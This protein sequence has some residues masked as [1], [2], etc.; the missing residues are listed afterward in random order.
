MRPYYLWLFTLLA[1]ALAQDYYEVLGVSRSASEKEIKSAYRA[2]SKKFHPDKNTGDEAHQR[3]IE[4]GEAYE[5]LGDAEKKST[6]DRFGAEGLKGGH[7]HQQHQQQHGFNPFG[8]LFGFGRQQQ[9]GKPRGG[10]TDVGLSV[11]LREFFQGADVSFSVEMQNVCEHCAGT[12]SS[13]GQTHQ[14]GTCGGSGVR[15]VKHQLAPGMFQQMQTTCETCRGKGKTFKHKCAQCAGHGVVR[16]QRSYSIYV[17]PGTMR[18]HRHVLHG[19]GDHSPDWTAGDLRIQIGEKNEHNLGYRRRGNS[20]YRTEPLT[21]KESLLGGWARE[22]AFLDDETLTLHRPAGHSIMDG[23]IEVVKHKG[24]P[25]VDHHDEFGDLYVE[26]VVVMPGGINDKAKY[27][28]D[29]L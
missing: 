18:N 17:E 16:M 8:D 9:R 20:L 14:C 29:E 13:D 25:S 5:V 23:E 12:G 7:Q 21:L 1:V 3:F 26:Y 28:R 24:M 2:L 15:V 22:I 19:E 4:I 11:T 10:D 27:L 6:Y